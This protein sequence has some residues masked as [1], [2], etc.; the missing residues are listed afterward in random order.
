[1]SSKLARGLMLRQPWMFRVAKGGQGK[2]FEARNLQFETSLIRFG[3]LI[4]SPF[5]SFF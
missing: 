2:N 3:A 5:S 4:F 1:M